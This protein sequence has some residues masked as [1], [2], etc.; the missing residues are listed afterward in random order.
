VRCVFHCVQR[1]TVRY[2]ALV[3]FLFLV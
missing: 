2:D 3:M 1:D